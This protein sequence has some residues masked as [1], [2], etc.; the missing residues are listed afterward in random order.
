MIKL[1]CVRIQHQ[2]LYFTVVFSMK[3]TIA[4][5]KLINII[6]ECLYK[7]IKLISI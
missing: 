7:N 2:R 5:Q 3:V 6:T 4:H 1:V